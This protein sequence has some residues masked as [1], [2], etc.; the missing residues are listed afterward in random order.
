MSIHP[1]TQTIM[2]ELSALDHMLRRE[3][4]WYFDKTEVDTVSL[5]GKIRAALF[6][7]KIQIIRARDQRRTCE[8]TEHMHLDRDELMKCFQ[9]RL[10]VERN[11]D[12][13]RTAAVDL[14]DK[15]VQKIS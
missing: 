1:P 14:Y 9:Q 12:E 11:L 6:E 3:E 10:R 8:I 15:I 13:R 2:D 5:I 7:I 4:M